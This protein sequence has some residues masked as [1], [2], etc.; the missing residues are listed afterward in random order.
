[1]EFIK[2]S[3]ALGGSNSDNCKYVEYSF[4]DKDMDLGITTITGRYPP[5][6]SENSHFCWNLRV[7][8]NSLKRA[9][10]RLGT[11]LF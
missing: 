7:Q 4:S 3:D 11:V 1:M 2:K 9:R 8:Q 10:Y 6:E 5:E